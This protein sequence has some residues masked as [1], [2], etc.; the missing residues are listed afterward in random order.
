MAMRCFRHC[1]LPSWRSCFS[2]TT[3]NSDDNDF[4]LSPA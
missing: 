1:S 4:C 3:W 2:F